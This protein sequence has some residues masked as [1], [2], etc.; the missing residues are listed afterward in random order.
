[1][2][3]NLDHLS[4]L[5][6]GIISQI[7]K[8]ATDASKTHWILEDIL[9]QGRTTNPGGSASSTKYFRVST[10]VQSSCSYINITR[11]SSLNDILLLS[12]SV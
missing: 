3:S 6:D 11:H 12:Q 7:V 5:Q 8:S 1:M 10:V 4:A 2:I 9:G